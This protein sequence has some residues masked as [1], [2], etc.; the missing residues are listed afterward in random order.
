MVQNLEVPKTYHY[1]PKMNN[2]SKTHQ[3]YESGQEGLFI[4]RELPKHCAKHYTFLVPIHIREMRSIFSTGQAKASEQSGSSE[5]CS[6]LLNTHF[7]FIHVIFTFL[8]G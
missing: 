8:G 6:H 4:T 5:L 2:V 1:I 7:V 3:N